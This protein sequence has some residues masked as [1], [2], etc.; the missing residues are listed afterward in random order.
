M[1]SADLSG[2]G[3]YI[4][5]VDGFINAVQDPRVQGN[6]IGSIMDTT[7]KAFYVETLAARESG[8]ARVNHVYEWGEEQGEVS[9]I[10]LFNLT[11]HG[12][13]DN[14]YMSYHFLPS[15]AYVPL[16]DP[17]R[18]GFPPASKKGNTLRRHV[19]TMKALVMETKSTVLIKPVQAKALFIPVEDS[20][21][22]FVMASSAR[23]NPGGPGATGGFASWWAQWFESRAEAIASGESKRAEEIVAATGQKVIRYAAGTK[24]NGVSVGGRF[25]SGKGVSYGYIDAVAQNAEMEAKNTFERVWDEDEEMDDDI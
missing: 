2:I 23:V 16:P 21:R 6:F 15:T 13:G 9:D 22:G 24:I 5:A 8:V 12:K 14:R 19:F 3:N 20:K 18:Y 7:R 17:S 25:A 1:I 11:K 10:R 4:G